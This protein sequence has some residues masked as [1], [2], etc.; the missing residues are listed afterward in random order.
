MFENRVLRRV[1]GAKRE[2]VAGSWRRLH[3]ECHNVYASPNIIRVIKSR[4]M[5]WAIHA[6]RMGVI[7]VGYK[8]LVGKVGEKRP[9]G[10]PRRRWKNNITMDS[11]RIDTGCFFVGGKAAGERSLPLTSIQCQG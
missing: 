3:N 10:E 2:E 4:K 11:Y 7:K 1:F 8:V 6:A 5:R 9:L